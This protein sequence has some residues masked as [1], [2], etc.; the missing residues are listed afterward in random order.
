MIESPK[1]FFEQFQNFIEES[2]LQLKKFKSNLSN[3]FTKS[4]A[5]DTFLGKTEK[6]E[7]AKVADSATKATQDSL[8]NIINTTYATNQ[9]LTEG[10]ATK[11]GA[12]AKAVS[13][14]TADN[15]TKATQDASGNVI[16]TT[17]ATK[18]EVTSG[19]AGKQPVGDYATNTALTQSLAGKAN[20]SHTHTKS[21][22]TD[23]PSIP[24]TSTLIPKSGNRGVL[25]GVEAKS[26]AFLRGDVQPEELPD[27]VWCTS[28]ELQM[29]I[30]NPKVS[31]ITFTKVI[32]GDNNSSGGAGITLD[33]KWKW[34]NGQAIFYNEGGFVVILHWNGSKGLVNLINY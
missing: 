9:T 19:L 29:S 3:Y 30:K 24:D 34:P 5:I 8:G 17:Y 13:A 10:L 26:T 18:S 14:G 22:I 23:F 32:F 12:T 21:Q 15:A 28:P 31:D 1:T 11:L 27:S 20:S 16:T 7:S 25:N 2:G 33:T 4:E 6:A